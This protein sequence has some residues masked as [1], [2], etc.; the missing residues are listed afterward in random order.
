MRLITLMF[1]GTFLYSTFSFIDAKN[2]YLN[3][4]SAIFICSTDQ[5]KKTFHAT[6][7]CDLLRSCGGGVY[8]TS[9]TQAKMFGFMSCKMCAY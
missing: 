1:F 5:V 8:S 3:D 2:N 6:S 4:N 7:S 9:K